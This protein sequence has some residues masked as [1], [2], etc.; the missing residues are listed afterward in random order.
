ML[1]TIFHLPYTSIPFHFALFP[2]PQGRL[3][4]ATATIPPMANSITRGR[5]SFVQG[6]SMPAFHS[7]HQRWISYFPS[8]LLYDHIYAQTFLKEQ[9]VATRYKHWYQKQRCSRRLAVCFQLLIGHRL[10]PIHR[11]APF[12]HRFVLKYDYNVPTERN[13]F[14]RLSSA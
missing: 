1:F 2:C 9:V 12:D 6:N 4:T 3:F 10:R 11:R 7:S 14:R 5:V 13:C 8:L